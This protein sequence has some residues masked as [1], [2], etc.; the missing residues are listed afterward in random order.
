MS[1]DSESAAFVESPVDEEDFHDDAAYGFNQRKNEGKMNNQWKT[2]VCG[3]KP[4][5]TRT[6]TIQE[7]VQ[8]ERP[9]ECKN[10]LS[11]CNLPVLQRY[12]ALPQFRLTCCQSC[13]KLNN[14]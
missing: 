12:C 3:P 6:C 14:N 1:S 5:L 4:T 2:F 13:A 7:C 8:S 9:G 10:Q 11:H